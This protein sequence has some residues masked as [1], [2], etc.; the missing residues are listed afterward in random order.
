MPQ[1]PT[2][3]SFFKSRRLAGAKA[4]EY[5]IVSSYKLGY[6]NREDITNLPPGVLVVG[7]QNVLTNVSERIQVRKGYTLYGQ[8]STVAGGVLATYDW[9]PSNLVTREERHVRA[10]G[11]TT[12]GNDGKLQFAYTDSLGVVTWKDLMTAQAS[13][14]FNFTEFWDT[15]ELKTL[16]LFVNGTSNIYEWSGG[17]TT[18]ASVTN[19]TITKQGTLSWAEEGFLTAGTRQI[20]IR[21][22][23]Y[24]YT[25][26]ETT[27]TLTGVTPDPT[28]QGANTPV[29]G[30]VVY[31]TVRTHANSS[32]TGLPSTFKNSIIATLSN[33]IYIGSFFDNAVYISKIN[34]FTDYSYTSPVRVVEEGA[35]VILDAYPVGF[36]PQDDVMYISSGRDFWY[37]TKLTLSADLAS[38]TFNVQRL[39]TVSSQGAQSQALITKIKNK[40]MFISN[41]PTMDELGLLQNILGTPQTRNLSDP[42][43][44][45]FD[46]YDF[47]DGS[48]VYN[49][50][51]IYVA[52]PKQGLFRVYNLVT[53]NWEAPQTG[54]F[55]RWS[56]INGDLYSHDYN[57]FQSYKMF[58]GYDDNGH[59][60]AAIA[61]FSYENLSS[62]TVLKNMNSFYTEGYISPNTTLTLTLNYETDGCMRSNSYNLDGSDRQFVCAISDD[63]SLGKVPLGINP[64][65]GTLNQQDPNGLPPKFRWIPTFNRSDYF[66]YQPVFSSNGLDNRFELLRFGGN[67]QFSSSEPVQNKA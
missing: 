9:L 42:I 33:Q 12:A 60:I 45:D 57:V 49:K 25:G 48:I 39:K 27:L 36:A 17:I 64:L 26:G 24:T 8:S 34:S 15:T 44:L 54:S 3:L 18:V 37:Q 16:L 41:E 61:A 58:D 52:V 46:S 19:N 65:G 2:N 51:F 32:L 13:V 28:A 22:V 23:V 21:G 35:R 7:S 47:T 66:E 59:P 6:R 30:D 43:K 4:K 53:A 11:L 29:A 38:Q 20:T 55:G 40:V 63:S 50:Y 56:I 10:G 14:S 62:P 31:Q 5:S 1:Q 67:S